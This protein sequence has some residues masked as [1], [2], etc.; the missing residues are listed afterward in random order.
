MAG[1]PRHDYIFVDESGDPAY[2]TD[3]QTGEL[4]SSE[5]Y[6][7][8]ALHLCD[9]AFG[10]VNRHVASFRYHRGMSRELKVPTERDDFERLV[11][12]IRTLAE[13]GLNL[14]GTAVYVDKK[15]FTGPYL[16]PGS[17]RAPNPFRF[18][19][20]ILQRLL[21]FHFIGAPLVTRQYDLVLDRFETTRAEAENL[22]N[23]LDR[24]YAVPT[25]THI[26]H[27]DSI[28]V[29]AL[30][31]VHH[32]ATG[33]KDIVAGEAV[34]AAL[35]FVRSRN[36]T[37]EQDIGKMVSNECGLGRPPCFGRPA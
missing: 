1:E 23:Y 15:R 2:T 26:T 16:K 6:V 34:P 22:R 20:F 4:L 31:I 19:N 29:E 24:S 9:D 30:Q 5:Y 10:P 18:R 25:P 7:A 33:F 21:A 11:G 12:P 36:L 13:S 28:Y 14:W 17:R 35:T 8:A 3:P 37:Q 27:A 32:L